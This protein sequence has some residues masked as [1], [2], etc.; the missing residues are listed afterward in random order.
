MANIL[1]TNKN[2]RSIKKILRQDRDFSTRLPYA[3][4]K[5]R[6]NWMN[7]FNTKYNSTENMIDK[8]QKLKGKTK[9]NFYENT[10]N[11][12][13]NKNIR[14]DGGPIARNAQGISKFYHEVLKL[15]KFLQTK[16]QIKNMNINYYDL[17]YTVIK[18]RDGK[19][20]VDNQYENDYNN[21]NNFTIPNHKLSIKP[22]E[23]ILK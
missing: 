17:Y 1:S 9:L 3:K 16:P 2:I 19:E 7:I 8:L 23:I 11:D 6:E 22:R 13:N 15:L 5:I 12:Y 21:F 20:I 14:M 18:N 4:K 10:S